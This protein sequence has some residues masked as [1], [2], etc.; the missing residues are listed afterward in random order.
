[1]FVKAFPMPGNR[2]S[3]DPAE[4]PEWARVREWPGKPGGKE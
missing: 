1:V 4:W 2:I 3:K